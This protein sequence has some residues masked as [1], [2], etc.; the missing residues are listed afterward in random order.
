MTKADAGWRRGS[1]REAWP[2]IPRGWRDEAEAALIDAIFSAQA[3]YGN[4]PS[5]GV[6]AVVGRWRLA[7]FQARAGKLDDLTE[8]ADFNADALANLFDNY[9]RVPG[10][11]GMTKAAAVAEASKA[12]VAAGYTNSKALV[13]GGL[14]G[15][16]TVAYQSIPGLGKVTWTYLMMLLG[17]PGVKADTWVCRF[18]NDA[19]GKGGS[20]GSERC[21]VG[22]LRS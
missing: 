8:I 12:L 5:T 15:P 1:T 18:V 6:R 17:V 11:N 9:Q 4:T 13:G 22:A 10:P 21:R 2:E 16:A 3:S 20:L 19:L 7:R 14:Y